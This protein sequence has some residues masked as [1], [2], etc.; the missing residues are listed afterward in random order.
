MKSQSSDVVI[1][2]SITIITCFVGNTFYL[3]L[4]TITGRGETELIL[5]SHYCTHLTHYTEAPF[6]AFPLGPPGHMSMTSSRHKA[7]HPKTSTPASS[8]AQNFLI[9]K[10]P[11][12]LNAKMIQNVKW[13]CTPADRG[14]GWPDPGSAHRLDQEPL[15]WTI[16][17]RGFSKVS[18]ILPFTT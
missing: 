9:W 14:S 13:H 3:Q 10:K 6:P 4:L 5:I 15:S 8:H 7:L 16:M 2:R 18:G 11:S 17:S 1:T 12:N